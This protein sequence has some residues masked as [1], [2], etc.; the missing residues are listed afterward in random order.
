MNLPLRSL[1][2][3]NALSSALLSD[4]SDRLTTFLDLFLHLEEEAEILTLSWLL[5]AEL[6]GEVRSDA[7]D[8]DNSL[9]FLL[10]LL[11]TQRINIKWGKEVFTEGL[12]LLCM[13]LKWFIQFVFGS[14]TWKFVSYIQVIYEVLLIW[15][16]QMT[17]AEPLQENQTFNLLSNS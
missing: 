8:R 13:T 14:T 3:L 11:Y 15:Q 1:F 2:M 9:L 6:A 4:L 10:C 16:S 5:W 12:E 7:K 17:Q